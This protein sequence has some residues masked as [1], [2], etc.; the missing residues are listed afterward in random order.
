MK[1]FDIKQRRKTHSRREI[2]SIFVE[3]SKV[4]ENDNV[5]L[6]IPHIVDFLM[7][8]F[9]NYFTISQNPG[10]VRIKEYKKWDTHSKYQI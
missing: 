6:K 10:T 2:Q 7:T 1:L 8:V 3:V 5:Q 9:I 4:C